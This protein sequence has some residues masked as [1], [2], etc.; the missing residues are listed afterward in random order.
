MALSIETF[1]QGNL[2]PYR[3]CDGLAPAGQENGFRCPQNPYFLSSSHLRARSGLRAETSREWVSV[4][5]D[6][7]SL[8]WILL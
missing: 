7:C 8:R 2:R 5:G 4:Q 6:E 3:M 1:A